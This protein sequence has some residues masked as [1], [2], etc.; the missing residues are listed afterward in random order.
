MSSSAS[1]GWP[2]CHRAMPGMKSVTRMPPGY[3]RRR[4]PQARR[5]TTR[6]AVS[7][8][9]FALSK[10]LGD[11]GCAPDFMAGMGLCINW[12]VQASENASFESVAG[13]LRTWRQACLDLPF[14]SVTEIVHLEALEIPE[15]LENRSDPLHWFLVQSS[16][17]SVVN[18]GT[19]D[20]FACPVEPVEVVGFTAYVGEGCEPMNCF[21]ARYPEQVLMGAN[22]VRPEIRGWRGASFAKT[23]YAS[24]VGTEHFLKCHLTITAA[25]DAAKVVGLLESVSD[26]AGYWDDRDVAKLLT[27][28]GRWNE[29]MAGFVGALEIET[30]ADL[31]A[32]IK[33]HPQFERLEHLGATGG[34][35]AM[36]RAVA[37]AINRVGPDVQG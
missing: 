12:T 5:L 21:L 3:G 20:E 31:P 34:T 7:T 15:R 1:H 8:G 19:P 18:R 24:A 6:R 32:P 37:A 17:Y 11:I 9:A 25:L 30:G 26:D 23:Q 22:L 16:A 36:A 33:E 35:A 2:I 10:V 14:D 4:V 29:M 27:T 13:Q 28:V